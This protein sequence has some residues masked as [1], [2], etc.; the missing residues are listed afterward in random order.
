MSNLSPDDVRLRIWRAANRGAVMRGH[1]WLSGHRQAAA[2]H[3]W[4]R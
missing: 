2:R 3:A 1:R 4:R